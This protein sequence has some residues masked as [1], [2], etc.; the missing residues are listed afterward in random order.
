M[1]R[2]NSTARF[3]LLKLLLW[4]WLFNTV[5]MWLIA[6]HYLFNVLPLNL[7]FL[8]PYLGPIN[9]FGK[10]LVYFYLLITYCSYFA[11]LAFLPSLLMM[12]ISIILPWRRLIFLLSSMLFSLALL[13]LYTDTYIFNLYRFHLNSMIFSMFI[14]GSMGNDVLNFSSREN[15]MLFFMIGLMMSAQICVHFLAAYCSKR[16]SLRMIK[17]YAIV[18]GGCLILSFILLILGASTGINQFSKQNVIFPGYDIFINVVFPKNMAQFLQRE[19]E[20]RYSQLAQNSAPLNYPQHPLIIKPNEKLPNIFI[21]GIDAWRFD[22]LTPEITPNIARFAQQSI[23]FKQHFSGGNATLPGLFSLFYSIP[24]QYWTAMTAS[25]TSP[26]LIDILQQFHYSIGIFASANLYVPPLYENIFV[27]IKH[28]QRITPGNYAVDRDRKITQ[29]FQTF[30]Q[31]HPQPKFAFL[32]YDSAHAYCTLQDYPQPFQPAIQHCNRLLLNNDTNL[33]PYLN[34]YRNALHFID[35]EVAKD[36][37]AIKAQG[38]WDNSIIIITSD[39]GQEFNDNHLNYWEHA[40]NFTR[41]QIQVP[42]VIHWPG[43]NAD[44]INYPTSHY[45]IVPTLLQ[46]VFHCRNPTNDYSIGENLFIQKLQPYLIV[47]SY[48]Y[49]GLVTKDYILS[50]LNSGE[51]LVQTLGAKTLHQQK[52]NPEMIKLF[53]NLLS[54]FYKTTT[55]S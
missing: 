36:L 33:I 54:Q 16:F 38:L 45:D 53:F 5:L 1:R 41:Y 7:Y 55:H 30:L 10:I 40:S 22:S 13:L 27:K 25:K 47:G 6:S 44:T 24:S 3:S 42:L 15:L 2:F 11:L 21:I 29:E 37:A 50:F 18:N 32:F 17:R 26:V 19:S 9:I 34:R 8:G 14:S 12:V 46:D 49:M 28:L 23:E 35:G 52:I 31:K 48:S 43:K 39:H 51:V 20:T 4:I